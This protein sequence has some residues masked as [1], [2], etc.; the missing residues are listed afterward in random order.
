VTSL[1]PAADVALRSAFALL[2]LG[3]VRHKLA[4]P[5]RFR[6]A[7][8]DYRLLPARLAAIAALALVVFE[9]ALGL[10]LLMGSLR[11]PA[12]WGTAALLALYAVAIGAN[13]LRGRRHVDCGC[14][15]PALRQPLS[16]WLVSRNGVLIALALAGSG[17]AGVRAL[18]WLDVITIAGT[19]GVAALAYASVNRLIANAPGLRELRVR[20]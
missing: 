11:V 20:P 13:L 7:V 16:G 19:V 17:P 6:A 10:A 4:D 8:A 14:V 1:D 18:G 15:G 2:W 9:A 5:D 3:A 12:L